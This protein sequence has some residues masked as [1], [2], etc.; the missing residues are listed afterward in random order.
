MVIPGRTQMKKQ[1][2]DLGV[3]SSIKTDLRWIKYEDEDW[4]QMD[5]NRYNDTLKNIWKTQKQGIS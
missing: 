2:G 4:I 3:E 1:V 5:Q